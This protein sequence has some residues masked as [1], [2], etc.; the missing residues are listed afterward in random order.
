[1]GVILKRMKIVDRNSSEIDLDDR[2]D[3]VHI[4]T[5]LDMTVTRSVVSLIMC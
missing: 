5:N 2:D 1:M 3:S 4:F